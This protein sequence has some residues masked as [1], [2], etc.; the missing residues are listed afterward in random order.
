[1]KKYETIYPFEVI[2]KLKEGKEVFVLDRNLKE[3][4]SVGAMSV[5]AFVTIQNAQNAEERFEF[6]IE[7]EQEETEE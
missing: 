5:G 2:N 3:V 1:M 4:R 7:E 6:W